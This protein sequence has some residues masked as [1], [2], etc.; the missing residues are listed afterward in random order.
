MLGMPQLRRYFVNAKRLAKLHDFLL[1][2]FIVYTIWDTYSVTES[3]FLQ[4]L[5]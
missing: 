3:Y 4:V 1:K 5:W 2:L